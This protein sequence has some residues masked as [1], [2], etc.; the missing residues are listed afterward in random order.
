MESPKKIWQNIGKPLEKNYEIFGSH[1]QH[2]YHW[3]ITGLSL[4]PYPAKAKSPPSDVARGR[5]ADRNPTKSTATLAAPGVL[6][7]NYDDRWI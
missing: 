4:C 6:G 7:Y 2:S 3:A 1:P 5:R